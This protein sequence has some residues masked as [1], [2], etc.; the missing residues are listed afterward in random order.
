MKKYKIIRYYS[1][2]AVRE[3]EAKD[4]AEAIKKAD[5]DI[6]EGLNDG[7]SM[8]T[9]LELIGNLEGWDEATEVEKI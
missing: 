7:G 5:K 6:F 1:T 9:E 4:E 3:V 8:S 2:Y